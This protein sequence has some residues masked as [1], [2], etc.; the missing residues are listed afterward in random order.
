MEK[1]LVVTEEEK[2]Q[3]RKLYNVTE[4]QIKED[5]EIIK[6]WIVKQPHLPQN[7]TDNVIEKF[8]LRNKFRVERTKQKMDNYYSLRGHNKD[9]I[10]DFENVVPSKHVTTY[11]PLPKLGPNLERIVNMKILKPDPEDYDILE[12]VK[13][14]LAIEEM[15]LPYDS[16]VG[17]RYLFDFSGFTLRHLT[18]INP[19][20]LAKHI[21]LIEKAYSSRMLG[22]ELVNFP[23]FAS[24]ILA[25]M[26]LVLRPKVYE[27]VKIHKDMES[28]YEVIPKECLP[29]EYGGTLG[30]IPDMLRKWDKA[31]EDHHDFFV[32]NFENVSVEHLRPLESKADEAFGMDGTFKKLAID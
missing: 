27:R 8:L 12:I 3:V 18:R 28:V 2:E 30:T 26:K 1:L 29:V 6:T 24:K 10:R 22:L 7:L 21:T 23:A 9:L 4:T 17:V 5:V 14:D 13:L 20:P 31:I 19:I 25:L 32:E 16:S 15:C 11:L